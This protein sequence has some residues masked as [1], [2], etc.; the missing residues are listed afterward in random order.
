MTQDLKSALIDKYTNER[1]PDD[2]EFYYKIRL[3]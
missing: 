3:Y 1:K 2:G